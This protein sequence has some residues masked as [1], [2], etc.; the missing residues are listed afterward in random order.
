MMWDWAEFSHPH[1]V[2]GAHLV[3]IY[4]ALTNYWTESLTAYSIHVHWYRQWALHGSVVNGFHGNCPT[5]T[6]RNAATIASSRL[7]SLGNDGYVPFLCHSWHYSPAY[8]K[9]ASLDMQTD[10]GKGNLHSTCILLQ[11]SFG[12]SDVITGDAMASATPCTIFDVE[13]L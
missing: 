5:L 1:G 7:H 4:I 6:R 3:L 12:H 2:V 8:N 9:L 11:I 10:K 13:Y